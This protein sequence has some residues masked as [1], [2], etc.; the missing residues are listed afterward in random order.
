ME[1]ST[2][3]NRSKSPQLKKFASRSDYLAY[4]EREKGVRGQ[5]WY[6]T[7][8]K[9]MQARERSNNER[10]HLA[11][12][13]WK[14]QVSAWSESGGFEITLRHLESAMEPTGGLKNNPRYNA[15]GTL[16]EANLKMQIISRFDGNKFSNGGVARKGALGLAQAVFELGGRPDAYKE[17]CKLISALSGITV[18]T[19]ANYSQE[20]IAKQLAELRAKQA[21][22][23]AIR[24][25]E[26]EKETPVTDVP[27]IARLIP[28]PITND[29]DVGRLMEMVAEERGFPLDY[30]RQVYKEGVI[31]FGYHL[32]DRMAKDQN[33]V[34][35]ETGR[36]GRGNPIV[37][38]EARGIKTGVTVGFCS[39]EI[40]CLHDPQNLNLP[41]KGKNLGAITKGIVVIGNWGAGTK[42]V[43]LAEGVYS[44]LAYRLLRENEGKPLGQDESILV[45][46][47]SRTPERLLD[48]CKQRKIEVVSLVDNDPAGFRYMRAA[49]EYCAQQEIPYSYIAPVGAEGEI[50]VPNNPMGRQ[51]YS[52]IS[53]LLRTQEI[54]HLHKRSDQEYL[55][56][57]M[58][59]TEKST[60]LLDDVKAQHGASARVL[61]ER[62]LNKDWNDLINKCHKPVVNNVLG[63][64]A[65]PDDNDMAD[66]LEYLLSQ[67]IDRETSIGLLSSSMVSK[68]Q[69]GEYAW[70]AAGH[71]SGNAAS[72]GYITDR[73][74][75][76][77]M[78]AGSPNDCALNFGS[79]SASRLVITDNPS[80]A[81][82]LAM[83]DEN[84]LACVLVGNAM[85]EWLVT[86]SR[87]RTIA[88]D[89]D[90]P[91]SD[92]GSLAEATV[93]QLI[94]SSGLK[95]GL[96]VLRPTGKEIGREGLVLSGSHGESSRHLEPSIE[97]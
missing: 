80:R 97:I 39:R 61:N 52:E 73:P 72:L 95:R 15:N 48:E 81:V 2:T 7:K 34:S 75:G 51:I 13:R 70:V 12:G 33:G 94:V 90:Y 4:L 17:A 86:L 88:I 24:K 63:L 36:I 40:R 47:G 68:T 55:V 42:R 37:V 64:P 8:I 21:Q 23:A 66:T 29:K 77:I 49:R 74:G 44:G 65:V 41:G 92:D 9:E 54:K 31:R 91:D 76:K 25:I 96:S 22:A 84:C 30:V 56:V 16:L 20:E 82:Q 14:A 79:K 28:E 3:T 69:A 62:W 71:G 67:G 10:W 83:E 5:D 27:K 59:T 38:S 32:Y 35:V 19:G 89:T 26:E 53:K 18:E 58:E 1:H 11:L 78:T 46:G 93:N 60:R 6:E 85:P 87:D 57:M 50:R 45:F 43:Y